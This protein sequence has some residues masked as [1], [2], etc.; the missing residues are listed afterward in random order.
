MPPVHALTPRPLANQALVDLIHFNIQLLDQ[1]VTIIGAFKIQATDTFAA[2]VGP[3]LRHVIEHYEALVFS[4]SNLIDYDNRERDR[5]VEQDPAVALQRVL[6]LQNQLRQPTQK[7]ANAALQVRF[8]G[9][10]GAEHQFTADSSFQ[11]ELLFVASHAVHHFAIIQMNC[12]SRDIFLPPQLGKAP[13][14]LAY[15]A[16]QSS[17][18]GHST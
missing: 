7:L 10:L 18:K 3:H 17:P 12:A 4:A 11:R 13:A 8:L 9:G 6:G 1:A 2:V 16:A 15:E 14:T 5:K